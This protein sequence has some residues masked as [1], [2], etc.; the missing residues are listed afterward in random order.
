MIKLA[1]PTDEHYPFQDESARSVA[2]QITQ[3]FKP[4]IRICGSDGLDFYNL[5]K[6]DKNPERF[7]TGL[8]GEIN[9]WK[10]GQAEWRSAASKAKAH[11][12]TGNHEDRLRSY[13]WR[14]PELHGL[15]AL[16]LPNLLD[17]AS[18]GITWEGEGEE[19]ELYKRAVVKHGSYIRK[20]SALS[21]RSELEA[22][23]YAIAVLTG[24]SHR[25][26]VYYAT[27]RQGVTQAVEC[28]C[29]CRLDPEYIR[30]PNWQQGL[31]LAEVGEDSLSIE[32][33]PFYTAQGK[34]CARW[35]GKEYS[36]E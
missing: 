28:F 7:R 9:A 17:F 21:A 18:L 36:E 31:V 22:E 12:L 24:H 8:Q 34:R 15:D 19:L 33:I 32:C 5:S 30:H 13:L 26:G 20:F 14:H 4:N 35:R 27:T 10:A 29:L 16:A 1:F 25:G 3:D 23:F 6:F 2:L 11:Y